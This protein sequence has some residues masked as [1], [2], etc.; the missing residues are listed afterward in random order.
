MLKQR[1]NFRTGTE[2]HANR[3]TTSASRSN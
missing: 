1:R 2:R 3:F